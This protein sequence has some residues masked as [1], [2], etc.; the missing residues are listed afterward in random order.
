[1][2]LNNIDN[3]NSQSLPRELG[4]T[5]E[6]KFDKKVGEFGKNNKLSSVTFS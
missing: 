3:N 5:L 4:M 1:M 2:V 6:R